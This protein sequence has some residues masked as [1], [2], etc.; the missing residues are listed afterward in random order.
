MYDVTSCWLK[1]VLRKDIAWKGI[2]EAMRVNGYRNYSISMQAVFNVF[3]ISIATKLYCRVVVR[4]FSWCAMPDGRKLWRSVYF[5]CSMLGAGAHQSLHI[6]CLL[7]LDKND[8]CVC[9]CVYVRTS[10]FLLLPF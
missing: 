5:N 3:F 7:W 2:P 8:V 10:A 1:V 4:D 6:K 9:V